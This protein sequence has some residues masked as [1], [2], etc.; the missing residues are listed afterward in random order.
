ME[1]VFDF[2]HLGLFFF[3]GDDDFKQSVDRSFLLGDLFHLAVHPKMGLLEGLLLDIALAVRKQSCLF[4]YLS[5][6]LFLN[7]L[8]LCVEGLLFS[9]EVVLALARAVVVE[10]LLS[11]VVFFLEALQLQVLLCDA[12]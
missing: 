5:L 10:G 7:L 11:G 12:H 9:N 8:Y 1:L 6:D 3:G 4:A 2:L